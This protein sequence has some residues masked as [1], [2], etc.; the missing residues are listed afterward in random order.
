MIITF[1]LF[2]LSMNASS[3]SS[4]NLVIVWGNLEERVLKTWA[5]ILL[6]C[7]VGEHVLITIT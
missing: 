6:S 4:V 1:T 2:S 3:V 5:V 7:D